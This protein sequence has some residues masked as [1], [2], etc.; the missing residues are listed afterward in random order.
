MQEIY[1]ALNPEKE[2]T[3]QNRQILG[4][5]GVPSIL[6][7]PE[8]GN[9]QGALEMASGKGADSIKST[10][11]GL[12]M[13]FPPFRAVPA[14]EMD[15]GKG[16]DSTKSTTFVLLWGSSIS[17]VAEAAQQPV[18]QEKLKTLEMTLRKRADFVKST[19]L[20]PLWGSL[21]FGGAR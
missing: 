20:L 10:S 7:A 6:A 3:L 17:V 5:C 1:R 14:L 4:F 21:R 15:S 19:I 12:F 13:G 11:F 16:A 9:P 8:A 18:L 2:R